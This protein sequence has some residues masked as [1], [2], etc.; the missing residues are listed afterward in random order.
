LAFLA[1]LLRGPDAL[2]T[3]FTTLLT[4][5]Q[6][7]P[8]VAALAR[9]AAAAHA[10]SGPLFAARL[11]AEDFPGDVGVVLSLLLNHVRLEPG[12][13]I[14][15]GAGNVHAYLRGSGVEIMA[16]SDN[17]LRCGLTPKH[18]D[19]QELLK[20]TEFAE[21][22]DPRWPAAGGHFD[23][24]VPD[25]SLTRLELD[26]PT[27]LHDSGPCIVLCTEGAATVADVPTE[28][29]HAAFVPAGA[30]TTIAGT[31]LVFIASVGALAPAGSRPSVPSQ[32]P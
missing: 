26:E 22:G 24:P 1:D 3:A 6:P 17:V 28:P 2:R 8:I 27:G 13:A 19:V 20:I 14:Y 7:A 21:L 25:F 10:E 30:A 9:R 18:I 11:A 15:L 16:N 29:G 31:G 12:E 32:V 4:H 5:P 23:V